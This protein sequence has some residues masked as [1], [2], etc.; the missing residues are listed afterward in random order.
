MA[1][2]ALACVPI[3]LAHATGQDL[4][5]D[6][7]TKV[8]LH[9][10]EVR[11]APLSWFAGDW[12]LQNHFYRPVST[13]TFELDQHLYG[14]NAAGYGWTNDVLCILCVFLLLWFVRELTDRPLFAGAAAVLFASWHWGANPAAMLA[15]AASVLLLAGLVF[16]FVRELGGQPGVAGGLAVLYAACCW[17]PG[18][19][20]DVGGILVVIMVLC[21]FLYGLRAKPGAI[22]KYAIPAFAIPFLFHEI[23]GKEPLAARMID[24]LPGRTAS[25]MSVFGLIA[26][27]AYARYE[28][29]SAERK[30]DPE[31]TP[32]TPPATRSTRL[33]GRAAP[34]A[35]WAWPIVA[36]AGL[37]LAMG[38]YEQGIM[39]APALAGLALVLWLLGYRVRWA[40]QALFFAVLA[41]YLVLRHQL[42]PSAPSGYQLQQF[43]HGP[44]VFQDLS[45]YIFPPAGYVKS[46]LASWD[47]DLG[48]L[49][50]LTG[51]VLIACLTQTLQTVSGIV[52]LKRHWVLA[53]AGW[54][55]S[56]GVFCPMAWLKHFDHYDYLP[57]ALRTVF[58]IALGW[59]VLEAVSS[60]LR[61]RALQA[62]P[63]PVPA[64][65]SLP[66]P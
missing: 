36:A 23:V 57:M 20:A 11:H 54:G 52:V 13:L 35:V 49:G 45:A 2:S 59:S 46:V 12:P 19:L 50:F 56:W 24:W 31:P 37:A 55:L 40:W 61:P 42:V 32:L 29:L 1:A 65:G 18:P 14:H 25:V 41:G 62:P 5:N 8:L 15:G 4:L 26:L 33:S 44:G 10:L 17:A 43:R 3:A 53:F 38:S 9:A 58:V 7:D 63:R 34:K 39:I 48:I 21:L 22:G 51:G 30:P 27:A 47:P 6:S 64:P 66:H 28:R 16:G 60:A